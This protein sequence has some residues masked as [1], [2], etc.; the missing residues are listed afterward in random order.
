M[1]K[2]IVY[3][4]P[5]FIV[6]CVILYGTLTGNPMGDTYLPAIPHIDKIIHAVMMGGLLA[7][8]AFDWQHANPDKVLTP[9]F[10]WAVFG[11]VLAFSIGD[12][13]LQGAIDNGRSGDPF[14]FLADCIGAAV[15]VYLAPPVIRSILRVRRPERVD[16]PLQ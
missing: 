12:E 3:Y 13:L 16:L 15:A 2:K 4:L 10:L 8:F 14:D 11:C 7:T 9:S 5:T 1:A 6:V